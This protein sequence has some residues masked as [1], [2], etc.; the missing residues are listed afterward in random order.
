[1]T[2]CLVH[3]LVQALTPPAGWEI[4]EKVG[5]SK[6]SLTKDYGEEVVQVDFT[7]REYVSNSPELC[8]AFCMHALCAVMG[9][10][11]PEERK[12]QTPTETV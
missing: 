10:R 9:C 11:V 12:W 7:A 2:V 5:S 4:T 8:S 3:A 6:V 1:M